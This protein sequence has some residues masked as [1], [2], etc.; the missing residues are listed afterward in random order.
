MIM[1]IF[2]AIAM[3]GIFL[4]GYTAIQG[5]GD[6]LP[7]AIVN[8]DAGQYGAKISGQLKENLPFKEIKTD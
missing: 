7:I 2:Y 1:G 6:K 3:L 4:P 5:N 8:S